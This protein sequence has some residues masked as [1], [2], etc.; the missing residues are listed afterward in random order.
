MQVSGI[1]AVRHQSYN[2][3]LHITQRS[4]SGPNAVE[5]PSKLPLPLHNLSAH[6]SSEERDY[7]GNSGVSYSTDYFELNT[8]HLRAPP[9]TFYIASILSL[10]LE[11]KRI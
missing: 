7:K 2:Q 4:C 3:L 9:A 8:A 11:V 5:S 6:K 10:K 1:A